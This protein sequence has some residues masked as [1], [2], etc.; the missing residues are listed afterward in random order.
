MLNMLYSM[1]ASVN[2]NTGNVSANVYLIAV[3]I[4]GVL[5]VGAVAAGIISKKKKK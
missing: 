2:P 4:A 3:I 1:T 5:I